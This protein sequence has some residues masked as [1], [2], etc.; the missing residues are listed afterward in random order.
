MPRR[1]WR[2]LSIPPSMPT[3][4]SKTRGQPRL[5]ADT[6]FTQALDQSGEYKGEKVSI[7]PIRSSSSAPV[8]T[9]PLL[10]KDIHFL[11]NP[12]SA[13]LDITDEGNTKNLDAI[14]RLLP[15][16]SRLNRVAARARGR[17]QWLRSFISKAVTRMC[18]RWPSG[19][20]ISASSAQMKSNACSCRNIMSARA[21]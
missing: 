9:D 5:F 18:R 10:S 17:V 16:E 11:F 7:A 20:W 13:Q 3:W 8:E 12:N 4:S 6:Q 1:L 15:G 14:K 21:A 19:P 2:H